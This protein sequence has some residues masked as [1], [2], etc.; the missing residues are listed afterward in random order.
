MG[1]APYRK[2]ASRA[3]KLNFPVSAVA[4]FKLHLE[5]EAND[6][7]AQFR[8]AENLRALG[9]LT[10]AREAL[11]NLKN[12]PTEKRWFVHLC[13]GELYMD[14]GDFH[15]AERY[16]RKSVKLNG[17]ATIP[18]VYLGICL[19]RQEKFNE[20]SAVLE[21]GLLAKGDIAEVCVNLGYVKRALG[22][23]DV[24]GK[25]FAKALGLDPNCKEAKLALRDLAFLKRTIDHFKAEKQNK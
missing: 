9:K 1:K 6:R 16:F 24:A 2:F 3:D 4:Y 15:R 7:A 11:K 13:W 17:G 19:G 10:D 20:A 21:S 18:W 23:Y 14:L 8:L 25:C 22:D 12:V 5:R